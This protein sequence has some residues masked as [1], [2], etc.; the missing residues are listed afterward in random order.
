MA[1]STKATPPGRGRSRWR[2]GDLRRLVLRRRE[3]RALDEVHHRRRQQRETLAGLA[4]RV[5]VL[6]AGLRVLLQ[7]GGRVALHEREVERPPRQ[8]EERHPDQFL[9]EE[10]LQERDAPVEGF[11]QHQDVDPGTMVRQHEVPAARIEA[12]DALD[13]E[14]QYTHQAE[15][16]A[17]AA[18]PGL[19]NPDHEGARPAAPC[20]E[21]DEQLRERNDHQDR[22]PEHHVHRHQRN[23]DDAFQR[24]ATPCLHVLP[25][26]TARG[27]RLCPGQRPWS[28]PCRSSCRPSKRGSSVA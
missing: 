21:R 15:D 2:Y 19:G 18:D 13:L 8:P 24:R 27:V 6:A 23:G 10:E 7:V 26:L 5:E 4:R 1:D 20:G 25:I 3:A 17:V 16:R 28:M 11:L 14:P 22:H 12:L 9:L